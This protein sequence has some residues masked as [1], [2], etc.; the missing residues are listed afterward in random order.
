MK[1]RVLALSGLAL[2]GFLAASLLTMGLPAAF[3]LPTITLT[4]SVAG[5]TV[6]TP[7][8]PASTVPGSTVTITTP[9]APA[10]TVS[11]STVP[12]DVTVTTPVATVTATVPDAVQSAPLPSTTLGVAPTVGE[13]P[14]VTSPPSVSAPDTGRRAAGP[15]SSG[16]HVPATNAVSGARPAAGAAGPSAVG[17][18]AGGAGSST[19]TTGAPAEGSAQAASAASGRRSASA[20]LAR[21]AARS[22]A[23]RGLR[24]RAL[25]TPDGRWVAQLRFVFDRAALVTLA[26]FGPAPRCAVARRFAVTTHP[27]SNVVRFDGR[28]RHRLLQPG[29][30]VISPEAPGVLA[31]RPGQRSIAVLVDRQGARPVARPSLDCGAGGTVSSA[32][33]RRQAAGVAGLRVVDPKVPVTA[34]SEAPASGI[35]LPGPV[36][37]FG[38]SGLPTSIWPAVA[39]L[40]SLTWAF[41]LLGLAIVDWGYA[42]GRFRIVR[43]LEA[44]RLEVGMLGGAF[45]GLAA[46]LFVMTRVW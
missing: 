14:S 39:L 26:L 29:V 34:R 5:V 41:L 35:R 23:L 36:T 27:G 13:S 38:F 46:V 6:P 17:T 30:Y 37:G 25:T 16:A 12:T 32:A 33:T 43:A 40:G 9:T 24:V 19:A 1:R 22:F 10:P 21:G 4:T 3:G 28:I 31:T 2:A 7:T 42:G 44:H 45:L 11:G 8:A 15:R 20:T 18:S